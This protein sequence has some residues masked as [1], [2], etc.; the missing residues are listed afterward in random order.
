MY[1]NQG[2]NA[3]RDRNYRRFVEKIFNNSFLSVKSIILAD[4]QKCLEIKVLEPVGYIC[5]VYKG[6]SIAYIW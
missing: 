1:L 4:F 2:F 6:L 3:I 5:H